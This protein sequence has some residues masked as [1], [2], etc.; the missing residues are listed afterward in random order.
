[1]FRTSPGVIQKP[2]LNNTIALILNALRWLL[3]IAIVS[4]IVVNGVN[5]F[6]QL[7]QSDNPT[8]HQG[9]FGI[10]GEMTRT[11]VTGNRLYV[12]FWDTKPPGMFFALAPFVLVFG[13]T[14]FALNA[15]AFCFFLLFIAIMGALAYELTKSRLAV[16]V[17]SLLA[18]MYIGRQL[19][20]E[21]TFLMMILGAGATWMAIRGRGRVTWT[22]GAGIL[23]ACGVL[24]KQPLAVA[25]P[26]LCLF[27]AWSAPE[28]Q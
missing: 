5:H 21:T 19:G 18:T 25:L 3:F 11:L 6:V 24:V 2:L 17:A 12:D 8:L 9:D 20:P 1:M 22:I 23:F 10:F 28:K 14:L 15:A 13:N 4:T 7:L 27:A 16:L 26:A